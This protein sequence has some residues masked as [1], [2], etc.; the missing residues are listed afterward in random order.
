MSITGG[1]KF[2]KKMNILNYILNDI[3][4]SSYP[5]EHDETVEIENG[6]YNK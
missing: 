5:I 1:T 3:I 4:D 6:Y 2:I